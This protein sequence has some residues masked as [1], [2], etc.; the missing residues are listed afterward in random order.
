MLVIIQ[1]SVSINE[2]LGF[3]AQVN[4]GK[5]AVRPF[6]EKNVL[7]LGKQPF[8]PTVERLVGGVFTLVEIS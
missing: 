2:D 8:A 3:F 5:N 4:P 7:A 1:V 6:L